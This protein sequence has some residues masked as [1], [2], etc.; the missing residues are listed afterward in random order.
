MPLKCR[1]GTVRSPDWK[2]GTAQ[3]REMERRVLFSLAEGVDSCRCR[4]LHKSLSSETPLP[5]RIKKKNI[6]LTQLSWKKKSQNDL[7]QV[8]DSLERRSANRPR[9]FVATW[10]R[11]LAAAHERLA[12]VNALCAQ[13]QLN[14]STVRLCQNGGVGWR[15]MVRKKK[16]K[17]KT[18]V[19]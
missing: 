17:Q 2:R 13:L 11:H 7:T 4:R 19:R 12:E 6:K 16:Q 3:F 18:A 15:T 10:T 9:D 8:V 1:W 5:T 14:K